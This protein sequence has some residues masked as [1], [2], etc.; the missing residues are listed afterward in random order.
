MRRPFAWVLLA[1]LFTA[2]LHADYRDSYRKA[3]QARNRGRWAEAVRFLREAVAE[4]PRETGERINISG[5][6]FTPYLPHYYLGLALARLGD[7]EAALD[8]WRTSE[9]QGTV[10]G[11]SEGADLLKGRRECEKRV[12]V[13]GGDVTRAAPAKTAAP[14]ST[15]EPKPPIASPTV[16]GTDAPA[17][18]PLAANVPLTKAEEPARVVTPP[19]GQRTA[20]LVSVAPLKP[21]PA[22]AVPSAP[23]AV[24][25]DVTT[26]AE[27]RKAAPPSQ[28]RS[29]FTPP[30]A[31]V[32]AARQFFS[33]QYQ[34]AANSLGRLSL[35]S[36]PAAA[37]AALLR[38]ATYYSLYLV[39]AEKDAK[40][41]DE[42]RGSV[43]AC[44]RLSPT[45]SPDPQAFSPRFVAFFAETGK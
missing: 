26:P 14:P 31:L 10:R 19:E 4:Q 11:S 18:T 7:C 15:V 39:G 12:L 30:P 44:R 33:G 2:T 3:I 38:A 20:P 21:E 5:M 23:V 22:P 16:V 41:L 40:L 13:A 29:T 25:R 28:A 6:D 37:H 9:A 17:A 24:A 35:P 32:G 42:A 8:A 1:C 43:R 36:G 34:D 27:T 45:L